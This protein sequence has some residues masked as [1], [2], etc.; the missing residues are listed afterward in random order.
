MHTKV[1]S[2]LNDE[3]THTDTYVSVYVCVCLCV[4]VCVCV[5]VCMHTKV[6]NILYDAYQ[7]YND[8]C[9]H[10]KVTMMRTHTDTDTH[11]HVCVCV[12]MHT[13]VKNILNDEKGSA[14]LLI[15]WV[16]DKDASQCLPR[17][18]KCL[19]KI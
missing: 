18:L 14:F 4:S 9:M 11:R 13:K 15:M 5:C 12:C 2:I 3:N 6:K 8:M 17:L 7:G 1:K 16:V 10:S 19:R